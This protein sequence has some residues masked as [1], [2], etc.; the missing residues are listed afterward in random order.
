M[1]HLDGAGDERR[2]DPR[3]GLEMFLNEYVKEQPYR[4]LATNVSTTGIYLRKLA[5]PSA[6]RSSIVGLEFELPGTNELIWARAESRFDWIADDFH[7]TGLRFTAMARKHERLVHDYVR[8]KDW[9]LERMWLRLRRAN[10]DH[11]ADHR[12]LV[13][14]VG[15]RS[16]S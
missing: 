4:A 16:R 7:L 3:I 13:R 6:R 2:E 5:D 11:R 9:L 15:R 8:E 10:E 12:S 14:S 1:Y